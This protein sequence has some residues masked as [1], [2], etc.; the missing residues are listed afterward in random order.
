MKKLKIIGFL[1]AVLMAAVCFAGCAPSAGDDDKAAGAE[2]Y[3]VVLCENF[4][5]NELNGFVYKTDVSAGRFVLEYKIIDPDGNVMD[6]LQACEFLKE[7]PDF[8]TVEIPE[9]TGHSENYAKQYIPEGWL[10]VDDSVL[11]LT[12][13]T[14][15][16]GMKER[17][18]TSKRYRINIQGKPSMYYLYVDVDK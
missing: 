15:L 14:Y 5:G 4:T 2:G 6:Y 16:F 8:E 11:R 18:F 7:H 9:L 3:K 12:L 10:P 17:D 1:T 13:D